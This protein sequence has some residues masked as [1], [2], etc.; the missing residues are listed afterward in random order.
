MTPRSGFAAWLGIRHSIIQA[1]MAGTNTPE[2][3]AA[4]SN[5]GGLGI[6]GAAY[7]TPDQITGSIAAIRERTDRPFGIN[8]FAGGRDAGQKGDP[9]RV[10]AILGRYHTEL[11]LAPPTIPAPAPDPFA[12]QLDAVLEAG[13]P[14]LSFTFGIPEKEQ[15]ADL[16]HRGIVVIGTATTVGEARLLEDAGVDAIVAQGSEAGAHRGTFAAPFDAAMVG[17]MALVPQVVD[18]VRLPVIAS[19]GIMD[20]RGIV[21]AEALGAS[22]VQLGTAFLTCPE[23]AIAPA[24]RDAILTAQ[25]EDT[26]TTRVFSGRPARGIVNEF[27]RAWDGQEDAVL[28]FPLQNGATRPLRNAATTVNDARLLSLWAGQGAALARELPAA[29]L[30]ESLV[31][32]VEAVRR[33]IADDRDDVCQVSVLPH[34]G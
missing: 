19:G 12:S 15:L 30:V 31:R 32:E 28:P 3:V 24:Y 34:R 1:P 5:A 17:T 14:V 8:L 11:G 4:V 27:M 25:A 26:T 21:A 20:G 18:A 23:T 16:K 7:L 22:A 29:E 13:V 2:L 6:F 33:A 10:L 9:K